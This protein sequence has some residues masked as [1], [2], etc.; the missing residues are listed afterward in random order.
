MPSL[1]VFQVTWRACVDWT[2]W[3]GGGRRCGEGGWEEEICEMGLGEM[4]DGGGI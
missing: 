1:S 2:W 3:M 4:V